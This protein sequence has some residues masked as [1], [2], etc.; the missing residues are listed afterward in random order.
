MKA[1]DGKWGKAKRTEWRPHYQGVERTKHV[2]DKETDRNDQIQ[3]NLLVLRKKVGGNMVRYE[4][5]GRE[6]GVR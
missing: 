3:K 1:C 5:K 4:Y 2:T 6:D